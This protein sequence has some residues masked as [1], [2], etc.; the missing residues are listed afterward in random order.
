MDYESPKVRII[1]NFINLEDCQFIIDYAKNLKLWN[2]GNVNS[3]SHPNEE[4]LKVF[5]NQ[6]DGRIVDLNAIVAKKEHDSFI[7]KVWEIKEKSKF[8]VEDF[9][10]KENVFLETW[11]VVRWFYP[12]DQKPHIDYIEPDFNRNTD[13]PDNLDM[14]YFTKDAEEIYRIYNTK[15]HYTSMLYLNDD[16][17]GG[18]LYFP[19]Y[20]NFTIK[21][22]PGM[23]V[24][25]SGDITMPHG[26]N[27]IT[28][29][30]RYVNTAFWCRHPKTGYYVTENLQTETLEKYWEH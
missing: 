13:V 7:K 27:Q 10:K 23:L 16:F 17:E 24:V 1:K 9:F 30:T 20:N 14:S 12:Y 6:W 5:S 22:E 26:I 3:E 25:F 28:S 2:S 11:E 29:G 21:P 19:T 4:H 15:K 8:Q 18:E